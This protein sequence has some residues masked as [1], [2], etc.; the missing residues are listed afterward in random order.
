VQVIGE[1][2]DFFEDLHN[3]AKNFKVDDRGN[4]Y[5]IYNEVIQDATNIKDKIMEMKK[6]KMMALSG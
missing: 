3:N 4:E 2:K 5:K 6:G 1:T